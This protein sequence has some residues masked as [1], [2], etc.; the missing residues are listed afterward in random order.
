M[1]YERIMAELSPEQ[2]RAAR[3]D[4]NAV[5]AAGAGSGKTRVL[6]A[7]FAYLVIERGIPVDRVL[8]LTFT[9]K[10][11]T[12]MRGRIFKIL[13]EAGHPLADRAVA[14]FSS[15]RIGTIDSFCHS[16]ARNASRR[17]GVAPDF[18]IDQE[19]AETLAGA[20]AL[21]FFLERRSHPAIARL[22]RSYTQAELVER[23]F[24]RT[25]TEHARV[26]APLDFD[27]FLR[28][29]RTEVAE[30]FP[31]LATEA[32]RVATRLGEIGREM[33][34]KAGDS[35]RDIADKAVGVPS[36]DDRSAIAAFLCLA[37]DLCAV[38]MI[39][40]KKDPIL[41][42]EAKELRARL[43]EELYPDLVSLANFAM[44]EG[45]IGEVFSLLAEFQE[46]YLAAI[47]ESGTLTFADVSRMA[48]D[49]LV[50]DPG[51]RRSYKISIDSIM[52]DE[53]QDD[54]QLQRDLLFLVA[55]RADRDERSVP[56]PEDILGDRLFFVG[57]EK[58][59]IYRFR[60]ADVSCFRRLAADLS[61]GDAGHSLGVNYRTERA[62]VDAFNAILPSVFTKPGD[63]PDGELP[64]HEASFAPIGSSRDSAALSPSFEIVLVSE[65]G[66]DEDLTAAEAE[67]GEVARRV[68]ELVDSGYLVRDEA[69]KEGKRA[70]PCRYSDV[71]IL[72]RAGTHQHLYER[73]L[74]EASIPVK[75]ETLRGLFNEAPIND[76]YALLRLA[77]YPHDDAAYAAL[78]R[79]PLA[80]VGDAA[81]ARAMLSRRAGR[82]ARKP[83]EPFAEE[84]DDAL[85]PTDREAWSRARDLY[86]SVR[87]DAD[88]LPAAELITRLWYAEGYRYVLL[89]DPSLHRYAE[90]F[91]Y[92]YELAR[93]DDLKGLPLA[94]FLDRVALLIAKDERVDGIDV[95]VGSVEGVRLMSVHK[96]KGL[97]FPVVFLIGAGG[98]G[99][100]AG[101]RSPVAYSERSGISV[102][103]DPSPEVANGGSDAQANY[104]YRR[105]LAAEAEQGIAELRRLLYVGMTRAE[106]RLAV[107]GR[108]PL[109]AEPETS[110]DPTDGGDLYSRVAAWREKRVEAAA[111]KRQQV[112][113]AS[114]IDLLLPAFA[115]GP[116]A[117]I[118]V[119]E[120]ASAAP[121]RATPR[122][123]LP[124][125]DALA[126][127]YAAAPI[128]SYPPAPRRVFAATELREAL[129]GTSAHTAASGPA[130]TDRDALDAL[131][132]RTEV[133]PADFGTYAHRAIEAR[134]TGL[135]PAI[136][137]DLRATV[138]SFADRFFASELG[139]L[140]RE[141]AFLRSEYEFLTRY[142][143]LAPT[144]LVS[145]KIDLVFRSKGRLF[146][147]DYKTDRVE[148]PS[149]HADQLA[150][151]R[152]AVR[153]LFG[154]EPEAWLFYLRSG[155]AIRVG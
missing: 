132:D 58:Q 121:R 63:W 117:G 16:I 98:S 91:D 127:R 92:F 143:T 52:I 93:R 56:G 55:E 24:A 11:A 59:S 69:D 89:E 126:A 151:Y 41:A 103:A 137:D 5:V 81:F 78:L 39:L 68:R 32:D 12:E 15:A 34:G 1:S 131:L 129:A 25:M 46:R 42:E 75:S 27:A 155:R 133:S 153:D 145:G 118:S 60:G 147:V 10:A 144:A 83:I 123:A 149:V 104:F 6:A 66:D 79:S 22:L 76:L 142:E 84:L 72:F 116:I 101:E 3:A 141:A 8:A 96:S 33:G 97:E 53:F 29:Q 50:A 94:V 64:L 106:V 49:A 18:A 90:F 43:K 107:V 113:P 120:V 61:G 138:D 110:A 38:K 82:E 45:H 20:L 115:N 95:P 31:A 135:A 119:E 74:R 124:S 80:P 140:A 4:R 62:L 87:N 105:D 67:A 154:A 109:A 148:D 2:L 40:P 136:P 71:A 51:L 150:V 146:V 30:R 100:R 17:Y 99:R 122:V 125:R 7:R 70:R 57:D 23:L 77:V 21:P 37:R 14:D 108:S 114:F 128:A 35:F 44:S 130:A 88:R 73:Y 111:E 28:A 85:P 102:N 139:G 65:P 54:N 112:K 47:R 13:R 9:E 36:L 26:S 152:K 48:V 19:G 134:F 86:R